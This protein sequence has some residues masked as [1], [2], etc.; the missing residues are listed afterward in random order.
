[1]ECESMTEIKISIERAVNRL[2]FI[3]EH[4]L[5]PA[6]KLSSAAIKMAIQALEKEIP[7][8]PKIMDSTLVGEKFWW[9]CGHCGASRHTNSKSNCCSYCGGKV[10]WNEAES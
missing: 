1:M 10:N 4:E 2:L 8:K 6:D 3:K 9:Y 7:K 5:Q